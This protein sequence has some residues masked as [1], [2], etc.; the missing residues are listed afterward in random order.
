M[1]ADAFIGTASFLAIGGR[2]RST[3][4]SDVRYP[5]AFA[6]ESIR[7]NGVKYADQNAR[8]ELET[9]FKRYGCHH[10]GTKKGEFVGD[11]MPPN[12]MLAKR[13]S[14]R[15]FLDKLLWRFRYGSVHSLRQRY[16]PQ[17]KSC[18]QVQ[19]VAVARSL[20]KIKI[21][22]GTIGPYL[23]IGALAALRHYGYARQFTNV[24]SCSCQ[25]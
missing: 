6:K 16:Y 22:R 12:G 19:S 20:K 7:A 15:N 23:V 3:L 5:G 13:R 14:L 18:S 10:C 8:R 2:F 25:L 21:H 11:H 9:L 24:N 1:A 17:C 4:G